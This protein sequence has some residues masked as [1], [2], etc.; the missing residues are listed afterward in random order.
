MTATIVANDALRIDW[1]GT[2][3]DAAGSVGIT[4]CPGR[5]DRRRDLDADLAVLVDRGVTRL[6]GLLPDSELAWAGVSD[7]R[8]RAQHAGIEYRQL[9]IPDQGTPGLSD[10]RE[11]VAWCREGVAGGGRVVIAC[12]GGLGRSGTIAACYLVEQGLS[13]PEAISAV[14]QA[15]GARAIETRSQEAFVASYAA[16]RQH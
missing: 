15:R 7:L 8:T 2:G 11:M 12:M 10:A 14:R 9:A 6:L 3:S 13:A 1:L 5:R 16:A 4:I